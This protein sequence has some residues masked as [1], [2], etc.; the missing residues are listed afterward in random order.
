KEHPWPVS[1][2]LLEAEAT[3]GGRIGQMVKITRIRRNGRKQLGCLSRGQEC[4]PEDNDWAMV[5]HANRTKSD[6]RRRWPVFEFD[7][8]I[9][10]SAIS[11]AFRCQI[12]NRR[13]HKSAKLPSG[14][15]ARYLE[16]SIQFD[17][18]PDTGFVSN[19]PHGRRCRRRPAFEG[20]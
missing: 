5:I 10:T 12:A 13:T 2:E 8:F 17:G 14:D 6:G 18:E 19:S 4:Q 11:A 15:L 3:E 20:N 7:F 1:A 16:R 9:G